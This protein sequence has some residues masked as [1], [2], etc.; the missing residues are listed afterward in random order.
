MLLLYWC[1]STVKAANLLQESTIF[2][3]SPCATS[4]TV[5]KKLTTFSIA[6]SSARLTAID[7]RAKEVKRELANNKP[8]TKAGELWYS[9]LAKT[10]NTFILSSLSRR[11]E[12]N[13]RSTK[14]LFY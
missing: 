4:H 12:L 14:K 3:R 13:T 11:D 10:I 7:R 2:V 8:K 9:Y 6:D 5:E 1:A